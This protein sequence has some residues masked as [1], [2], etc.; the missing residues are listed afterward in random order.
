MIILEQQIL[1]EQQ[2]C[3]STWNSLIVTAIILLQ[4]HLFLHY[5]R[6]QNTCSEWYLT[7][8]LLTQE[9]LKNTSAL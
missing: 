6:A 9:V 2:V 1:L 8:R 5:G 3:P 7:M 4:S